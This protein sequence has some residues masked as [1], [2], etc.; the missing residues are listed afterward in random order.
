METSA[1]QIKF[2]TGPDWQ[3]HDEQDKTKVFESAV[4]QWKIHEGKDDEA[5]LI[6]TM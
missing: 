4:A 5:E 1:P 3:Y 2:N 6:E